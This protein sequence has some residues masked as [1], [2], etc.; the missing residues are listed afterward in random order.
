MKNEAEIAQAGL[1]TDWAA[2][3]GKAVDELD[4]CAY[5]GLLF[6]IDHEGHIDE[7]AGLAFCDA[8]CE[9]HYDQETGLPKG[10]VLCQ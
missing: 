7:S 9:M 3:S 10:Y 5:C 1:E 6:D 8:P 4:E 2:D